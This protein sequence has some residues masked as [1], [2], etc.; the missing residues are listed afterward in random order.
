MTL[1]FTAALIFLPDIGLWALYKE[2][3]LVKPAEGAEAQVGLE[4]PGGSPAPLRGSPAPLR[5]QPPLGE[6]C[7]MQDAGA[8][9]PV[10]P[11]R[12]GNKVVRASLSARLGCPGRAGLSG[13]RGC[14]PNQEIVCSALVML[15]SDF[16]YKKWWR[17]YR[18][19]CLPAC[20]RYFSSRCVAVGP[21]ESHGIRVDV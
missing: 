16:Y 13:H 6:G 3:Q 9:V 10:L 2:K 15:G 5:A 17:F 4:P 1:L 18:N 11:P 20:L 19:F 7:G 8:P 21:L 12:R 14:L